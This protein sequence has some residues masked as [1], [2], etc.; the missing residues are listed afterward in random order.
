VFVHHVVISEI[1]YWDI[2]VIHKMSSTVIT[3]EIFVVRRF[4]SP[5]LL[6][7]NSAINEGLEATL[8][9]F[10][11]VS[12]LFTFSLLTTCERE[13]SISH[14]NILHLWHRKALNPKDVSGK[15]LLIRDWSYFEDSYHRGCYSCLL[16]NCYVRLETGHEKLALL[17]PINTSDGRITV[18]RNVYNYS[19]VHAV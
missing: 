13:R 11:C 5:D 7:H 15:D 19:S 2:S 1:I 10:F 17:G 14:L 6:T 9:D 4:R 12:D 8:L 16:V 3:R 18:S